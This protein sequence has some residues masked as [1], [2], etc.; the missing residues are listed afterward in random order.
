M[1]TG[2]FKNDDILRFDDES[3]KQKRVT[4]G[5]NQ[6]Q[7]AYQSDYKDDDEDDDDSDIKGRK[8]TL[9]DDIQTND[10]NLFMEIVAHEVKKKGG[11]EH[12]VYFIK[13]RD[14]LGLID[15]QRR[16]REML[17]LRDMLYSRYP[18]LMIPPMPGK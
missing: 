18:G 15:I 6:N 14:N 1:Q 7:E 3:F 8:P 16:Y 10:G 5:G 11:K 13:G 17:F 12:T 9:I 2:N 4:Y